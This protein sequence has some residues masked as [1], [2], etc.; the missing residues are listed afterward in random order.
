M[1]TPEWVATVDATLAGTVTKHVGVKQGGGQEAEEGDG[2]EDKRSADN[3][4]RRL[5]LALWE[6]RTQWHYR[7]GEQFKK[8][9]V[10]YW[11]AE[12]ERHDGGRP[13]CRQY[14]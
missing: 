14:T 1:W 4:K 7:N 9:F 6:Q 12:A 3:C 2:A 11:V 13:A 5:K 10:A 8:A